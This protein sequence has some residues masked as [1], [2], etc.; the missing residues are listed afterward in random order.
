MSLFLWQMFNCWRRKY[1]AKKFNLD[2]LHI[3][4]EFWCSL[5]PV[6]VEG[7]SSLLGGGCRG[8]THLDGKEALVSWW[9]LSAYIW[10]KGR[11]LILIDRKCLHLDGQGAV[12]KK[13]EGARV[14]HSPW[15]WTDCQKWWNYGRWPGQEEAGPKEE[16]WRT[17]CRLGPFILLLLSVVCP[18]WCELTHISSPPRQID[19]LKQRKKATFSAPRRCLPLWWRSREYNPALFSHNKG[20]LRQWRKGNCSALFA[21]GVLGTQHTGSTFPR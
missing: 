6:Q 12:E 8:N 21:G 17:T 4:K 2:V 16:V 10:W 20:L 18:P 14:G 19:F 3:F 1:K 15:F 13:Q 5:L 9:T 11:T 7:G